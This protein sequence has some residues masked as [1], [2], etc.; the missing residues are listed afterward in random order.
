MA[1][2]VIIDNHKTDQRLLLLIPHED[3]NNTE[4]VWNQTH[5]VLALLVKMNKSK[6]LLNWCDVTVP[7]YQFLLKKQFEK[8]FDLSED[9][10]ANNDNPHVVTLR[11]L[12]AAYIK[13]VFTLTGNDVDVI[14]IHRINDHN[15]AFNTSLNVVLA[16]KIIES[17][18][19]T[20]IVKREFKVVVDNTKNNNEKE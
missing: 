20:E 4:K 1:T 2:S 16:T 7:Q 14:R 6:T 17:A 9:D 8:F 11:F 13:S 3:V 18:P 12:L 15:F 19:D 10:Q 5:P